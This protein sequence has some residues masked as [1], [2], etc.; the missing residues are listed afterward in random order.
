MKNA[1][2][3]RGYLLKGIFIIPRFFRYVPMILMLGRYCLKHKVRPAILLKANTSFTFG[4]IICP[5]SEIFAKFKQNN[6][7]A[8]LPTFEIRIKDRGEVRIEK[9]KSLIRKN[10]LKYPLII[11]PD[12]GLAGIGLKFIKDEKE[13][14]RAVGMIK[15]DYVLQQYIDWPHQ[16]AVF[17]IKDP[18]EEKGKIWSLTKMIVTNNSRKNPALIVP[19]N[20]VVYKDESYLITPALEKTFNKI[21][22]VDGF[23]FGRFDILAKNAESFVKEGRDFKILEVNVG[24]YAIA[25]QALDRRY[26]FFKRYAILNEQL[27]YAFAIA[28]KNASHF[29]KAEIKEEAKA[30]FRKYRNFLRNNFWKIK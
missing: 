24:P 2:P 30:F 1:G 5:K 17:Y 20:H 9:V 11:K 21:S 23:F 27:K 10:N 15:E 4:G 26:N 22:E 19:G 12:E 29:S 25:L 16:M 14:R 28:E 7:E 18:A 6:H 8:I 13:L 3:R